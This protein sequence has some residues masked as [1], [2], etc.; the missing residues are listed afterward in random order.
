MRRALLAIGL[1]LATAPTLAKMQAKPVEW[2]VGEDRFSGYV[3]YDDA[4]KAQRP[5]LVQPPPAPRRQQVHPQPR[6][7]QPR[8][9]QLPGRQRL[10]QP[11]G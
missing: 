11:P 6:D 5:G 8:R 1:L 3:V 9:C 10:S 7:H 2:S 4:G